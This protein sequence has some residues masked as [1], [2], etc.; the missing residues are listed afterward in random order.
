M[1]EGV[2]QKIEA[3]LKDRMHGAAD[4]AKQAVA[5]MKL[6]AASSD[7]RKAESFLREMAGL[8]TRLIALRPSMSAPICSAIARFFD[9]IS[10]SSAAAGHVGE[11]KENAGRAADR[12]LEQADE[13]PRLTAVHVSRMIPRRAA[14]LTHSY[15]ETCLRSLLACAEKEIS[16]FATESRPLCEGRTM[17]KKLQQGGV[18][19]TL[20]TDAEAGHF[21]SDVTMVLVGADSVLRDGSVINKVG[22]YLIALAARDRGVPFHVA[23]DSWKFRIE[24]GVP[25]LEEKDP[26]E[27][28]N[29]SSGLRARNIYFDVTPPSL[30]TCIVTEEGTLTPPEVRLRTDKWIDVLRAMRGLAGV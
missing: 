16:V 10:R 24:E 9:A 30:I 15:S 27:I 5:I 11:V 19:V 20:I 29:A 7:A 25:E 6:A 2:E 17:A 22:T 28:V 3:I 4:L 14:V 26:E 13:M 23:S 21:M 12:L 18:E 8:G 1:L